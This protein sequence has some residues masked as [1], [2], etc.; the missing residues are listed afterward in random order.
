MSF[1]FLG[2]PDVNGSLRG[3]AY[4]SAAFDAVAERGH[5]ASPGMLLS[6]D[7]RDQVI[8]TL[9]PIGG[10]AGYGDKLLVQPAKE[11]LRQVPWRPGDSLCLADLAW[12][13]G[14]PCALSSRDV[15]RRAVER[16]ALHGLKPVA[17]I[18]YE[19]RLWSAADGSPA[20]G[21]QCYSARGAE[22]MAEFSERLQHATEALGVGL[23]VVHTEGGAGLVELNVGAADAQ[24][25]ADNVMFLRH[26]VREMA[27]RCGLRASFLAKP[28]P[29]EEGSSGHVHVSLWNGSHNAMSPAGE[30]ELPT[31]LIHSVGG[32]LRHLPAMSLLLN[33]NINS[34]KRVVPGFFASVNVSWGLDNRS[35]SVRVVTAD[36]QNARLEI[37]RPGADANPYLVLAAVLTAITEGIEARIDPPEPAVGDASAPDGGYPPLPNSLESA[38]ASFSADTRFRELLGND[39]SDYFVKT[40]EWEL[41]EWQR[42]VS[43]WERERYELIN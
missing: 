2:F 7:P 14:T 42:S 16:L 43:D 6:L 8:T 31:T 25:A 38:I 29:G 11:T 9:D 26:A 35:T 27:R 18:E 40:R 36:P 10:D 28:V 17:A 39:F 4:A 12:R 13:D 34:Y 23:S 15:L 22:E 30:T 33:P 41:H 32:L 1:T 37:R 20:T 3:K 21:P 19:L 24:D 5:A